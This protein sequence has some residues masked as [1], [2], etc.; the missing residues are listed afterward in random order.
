MKFKQFIPHIVAVVMFYAAVFIVFAPQFDGKD[1]RQGDI[2]AY[3]GSSAE[4][5]AYQRTEGRRM[6][7]T[8]TS[9]GGMPTYQVKTISKGNLLRSLEAPI[10]SYLGGAAGIFFGGL[11]CAYLFLIIVGVN[12][13]LSI[14]GAFAIALATNNMVLWGAG[15]GTKTRTLLYLPLIASGLIVAFRQKYLAGGVLFALG[16]GLAILSNHPQM[17]YYFGITVPIFGIAKLVQAIRQKKLKEFALASAA[18]LVG[19]I[20]ALGAGASNVLPTREYAA[21]TMRGGQVLEKPVASSSGGANTG[22]GLDWDYAMQWS[23]GF[24]DAIA[25]YAPMAAGGGSGET[26]SST[27]SFGKAIKR[28]GFNIRSQFMAPLY[29]GSLPFTEGPI[30]LGAVVWAIFIFGLFTAK[31]PEAAWLGGGTLLIMLM[32]MGS[33]LEGFN[34]FLFDNVPLLNKFRTPNS[35]LSIT[36]FMMASLGILGI[37]RWSKTLT[38][39]P[40]RARKQLLYAGITAGTLGFLVAVVLPSFITFSGA[41]DAPTLSRMLGGADVGANLLQALEDTRQEAY[42]DSA[43]RSFLYVGLTFG[44]LFAWFKQ[45]VNPTIAGLILAALV[46]FD[47]S[48]INKEYI[49]EDA[50]VRK[51]K[52]G[53]RPPT[54]PADDLI[55]ADKDP[56]FR[57]LNLTVNTFNDASTSFYHKSI[58]GYSAVKMRRYQDLIDGYLL[59]R[60]QDVLN[61]LNTKYF[62]VPGENN[63][64]QARKNPAAYGNAWLVNQ[65]EVVSS[66]T[67]EFEALGTVED[68]KKTAIV[69]EDFADVVA[70]ISP[71]GEGSIQLTKYIPDNLTYAFDSPSEQLVVF[72]EMWYGPDLG[73]EATIDGKPAEL[74]RT[75]YILRGLRVP[76]G[77]H[78]IEMVFNP[79]SYNLGVTLSYICSLLIIL[80]AAGLLAYRYLK[81]RRVENTAVPVEEL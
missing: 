64:P 33:N 46:V 27:S 20:V 63:T 21:A 35:A 18:L 13:W 36:T 19:L 34:R 41:N 58:G 6:N 40:E 66:N 56:N 5:G 78:E 61:M 60:D 25:T 2:E 3:K 43:W 37:T 17:L 57:V 31:R 44:L 4:M 51:R 69:H 76:A 38:K 1:L 28:A 48:G 30:Y 29:H 7:W 12:P 79:G 81:Q 70:G 55:L 71:S 14:A 45:L 22:S 73:W 8:G 80:G 16:M 26:V 9:F 74:I 39:S 11:I 72:S 32:A 54:T 49:G 15:H 62:I 75:N 53:T 47:F 24:K 67:A 23:N 50:W 68:L 42:S 77:Q 59:K 52:L 65:V 10:R